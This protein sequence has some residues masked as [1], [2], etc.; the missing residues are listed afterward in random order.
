[1]PLSSAVVLV[2]WRDVERGDAEVETH[3]GMSVGNSQHLE[4]MGAGEPETTLS[5]SLRACHKSSQL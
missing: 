5:G 2:L 1:M 4:I 3:A